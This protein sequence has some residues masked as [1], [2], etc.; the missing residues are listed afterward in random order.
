MPGTHFSQVCLAAYSNLALLAHRVIRLLGAT[1]GACLTL[2]LLLLRSFRLHTRQFGVNEDT[3]AIFADDDLLVHLDVELTLGRNLVEATATG[4]TLHIDNAQS[5]AR[6]LPDALEAA[7]Q[8]G[9]YG[10]HLCFQ[11]LSLGLQ[12]FLFLSSFLH[13]FIQFATL[14][15][16][17]L[18]TLSYGLL[19]LFQLLLSLCHFLTGLADFL[20]AELNLEFLKLY[21]LVQ[22]IIFAI[23]ADIVELFFLTLHAFLRLLN[24]ISLC[25]HSALEIINFP[26]DLLEAILQ[27]LNLI[28]QVTHF[29]RQLAT[30]GALLVDA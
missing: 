25:G 23:V 10:R 15:L 5:I 21:F 2:R 16:K 18:L 27:S 1:R 30:E 8:T 29:E 11:I 3:A 9:V 4:I 13:D 17:I 24:L 6:A 28:L 19:R 7:E 26:L 20:V 14:Q 22:R 12:L